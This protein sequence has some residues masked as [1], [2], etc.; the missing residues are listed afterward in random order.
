[1]LEMAMDLNETTIAGRALLMFEVA[2][3]HLDSLEL[4][5]IF[6][7]RISSIYTRLTGILSN[8][9]NTFSIL[10]KNLNFDLN[11]MRIA[12]KVIGKIGDYLQ[13]ARELGLFDV[14]K[15]IGSLEEFE[16]EIAGE[17]GECLGSTIDLKEY[18]EV[19]YQELLRLKERPWFNN[20]YSISFNYM[21]FCTVKHKRGLE[22]L[23]D[24]LL[25]LFGQLESMVV[26][27]ESPDAMRVEVDVTETTP[28][29][30]R[31]FECL[32]NVVFLM[33]PFKIA[34]STN[35][36]SELKSFET[37]LYSSIQANPKRALKYIELMMKNTMLNLELAS[38]EIDITIFTFVRE[39][40]RKVTSEPPFGEDACFKFVHGMVGMLTDKCIYGINAALYL[41]KDLILARWD[42]APLFIKVVKDNRMVLIRALM[43]ANAQ[44]D[45]KLRIRINSLL[46]DN[47][48]EF[49]VR[50]V[51]EV[52]ENNVRVV[53]NDL[54]EFFRNAK[55]FEDIEIFE[56]VTDLSKNEANHYEKF[57]KGLRKLLNRQMNTYMK[58]LKYPNEDRSSIWNFEFLQ[59]IKGLL[60]KLIYAFDN[61]RY[62]DAVDSFNDQAKTMLFFIRQIKEEIYMFDRRERESKSSTVLPI[63]DPT[64][65]PQNN[66]N[67]YY[68]NFD[69]KIHVDKYDYIV[70]EFCA[71]FEKC[72]EVA[73]RLFQN[74][75]FEAL[76]SQPQID[77]LDEETRRLR[78]EYLENKEATIGQL[79]ELVLRCEK[80]IIKSILRIVPYSIQNT[81]SEGSRERD[82]LSQFKILL[83]MFQHNEIRE[84]NL[85]IVSKLVKNYPKLVNNER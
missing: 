73:L 10:R 13:D 5:P 52:G 79:M 14:K 47:F 27:S 6:N 80:S 75:R 30:D 3:S 76:T 19:L 68:T 41:F 55:N 8:R 71:I 63:N 69:L 39:F 34:D 78:K 49:L 61:G 45:K 9:E 84:H 21:F 42:S 70:K 81:P 53:S 46:L 43:L 15:G 50:C 28:F 26:T 54:E 33:H 74:N 66:D 12:G 32:F 4:R 37:H 11:K 44:I 23:F 60:T 62:R 22:K 67:I 72:I 59:V 16:L 64:N 65:S 17:S 56:I 36:N 77:G 82:P 25:G 57:F 18:V 31:T 85:Y 1:M 29:F 7:D 20:F 51:S 35:V 2:T 24:F 58:A 38:E 48:R 40:L 83:R